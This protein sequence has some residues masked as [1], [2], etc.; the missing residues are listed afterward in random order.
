MKLSILNYDVQD[1]GSYLVTFKFGEQGFLS[2]IV[3]AEGVVPY[4]EYDEHLQDILHKDVGEAKNMNRVMF[5]I[6]RA[7]FIDLPIEI[8]EF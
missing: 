1:K 6:Y 2:N 7:E 5:K 4:I 3:V 8:G